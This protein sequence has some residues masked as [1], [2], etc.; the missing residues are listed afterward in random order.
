LYQYVQ[1][2]AEKDL[3]AP[4]QLSVFL[5]WKYS[6]LKAEEWKVG[7]KKKRKFFFFPFSTNC[8]MGGYPKPRNQSPRR[9]L[10]PPKKLKK[11]F[12]R[13]PTLSFFPRS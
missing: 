4:G 5:G 9:R 3:Q 11:A 13:S 8:P 6:P 12:W 2:G 1:Q 7:K 10:S